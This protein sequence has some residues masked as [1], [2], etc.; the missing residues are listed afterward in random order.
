MSLHYLVK[1][2]MLIGH[3]CYHWVVRETN[4]RNYHT[5]TVP[6]SPNSPDLNVVDYSVWG[7]LQEKV[8]KIRITDLDEL[9]Q[10]LRAVS[11]AGSCRHCG[12]HSSVASFLA[13]GQVWVFFTPSL[14]IYRTCCYQLSTN[15]A[16]VEA[17]V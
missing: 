14:V 2:E 7:L 16:N 15:L 17:T 13:P 6:P 9:K 3:I 11:K 10:R 8:Y 12:S 1:L 4:S 5:L